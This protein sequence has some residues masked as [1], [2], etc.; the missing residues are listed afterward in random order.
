MKITIETISHNQ[1]RYPTVGDW[2][3]S[4]EGNLNIKVSDV[5]DIEYNFLVGRHEMDEAMLC[6]HEGV[7]EKE[8]DDYDFSHPDAGGDSFSGSTD[9]PYYQQHCDALA[10]EW[11]MSR[12]LEVDWEQYS[13]TLEELFKEESNGNETANA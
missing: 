13:D 4:S 1:Q 9:A 3:W 7:T 6:R 5:G 11:Q 10:A 12:L 8:V 2:Q